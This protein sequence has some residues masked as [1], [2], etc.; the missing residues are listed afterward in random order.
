[1]GRTVRRADVTECRQ[2]LTYCD[3]VIAPATCVAARCPSLYTYDDPLS[4]N[5]YMGCAHEVFAT[6]I[7]VALFEEAERG[8]GYGTLKLA[9]EP[10]PQC[11]FAV[12]KA[13]ERAPGHEFRCI[14]RRFADFPD[15]A[16]GSVRAF[17]LRAGLSAA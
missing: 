6:E 14:N 2:C 3:R 4:G 13:H 7:D 5:R 16:P 8:R 11:A 15:T 12:E 10:L 17:D 1:M 9:R